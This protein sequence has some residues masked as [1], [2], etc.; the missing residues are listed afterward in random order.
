MDHPDRGARPSRTECDHFRGYMGGGG[1]FAGDRTDFSAGAD[2]NR[3]D[4]T[5]RTATLDGDGRA[6]AEIKE[7]RAGVLASIAGSSLDIE[8]IKRE[9]R[10]A[11]PDLSC[12]SPTKRGTAASRKGRVNGAA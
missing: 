5:G 3:Q 6:F 10:A 1:P 2:L 11:H 9:I 4:F 7:A 8:A 12:D